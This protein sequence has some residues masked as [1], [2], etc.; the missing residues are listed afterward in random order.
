VRLSGSSVV[1]TCLHPG[2]VASRGKPN[3]SH[4]RG[5]RACLGCGCRS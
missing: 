5:E 4:A 1:A 2:G 3:D